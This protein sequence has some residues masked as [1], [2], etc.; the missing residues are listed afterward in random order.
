MWL[1]LDAGVALG[2]GDVEICLERLA[3]VESILG[4]GKRGAMQL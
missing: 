4:L 1:R 3:A 2:L